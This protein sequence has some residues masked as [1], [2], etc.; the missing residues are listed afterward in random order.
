MN[1]SVVMQ[2]IRSFLWCSLD[3]VS[4]AVQQMGFSKTYSAMDEEGIVRFA[5]AGCDAHRC[6]FDELIGR[7]FDEVLEDVMGIEFNALG[8]RRLFFD[9]DIRGKFC[10][11]AKKKRRFLCDDKRDRRFSRS[12]GREE[13]R[14]G[15][16][17][18]C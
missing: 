14:R 1:P 16:F 3:I 5:R 6:R 11:V 8:S 7:A 2:W 17:C 4:D 13:N 18:N 10:R 15:R 12:F 9:S